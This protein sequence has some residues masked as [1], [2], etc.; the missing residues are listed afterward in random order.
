MSTLN[1]GR[2]SS[3]KIGFVAYLTFHVPLIFETTCMGKFPSVTLL[4]PGY[5][6]IPDAGATVTKII[7]HNGHSTFWVGSMSLRPPELSKNR[8]HPEPGNFVG[9]NLNALQFEERGGKTYLLCV[10]IY[11]FVFTTC[12]LVTP[13]S[14]SEYARP[15]RK[16]W[17]LGHLDTSFA[18]LVYVLMPRAVIMHPAPFRTRRQPSYPLAKRWTRS[19]ALRPS[20]PRFFAEAPYSASPSARSSLRR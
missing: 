17:Y 3:I 14:S 8:A 9:N 19:A 7:H 18:Q 1:S 12:Y 11:I 2:N 5:C 13:I 10:C 6:D 4:P 15:C 16:V 20:A